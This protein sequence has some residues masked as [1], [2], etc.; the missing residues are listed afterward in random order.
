MPK[1]KYETIYQQIRKDITD[2]T[3]AFG[4]YLPSENEYAERFSCTRNTVRRAL[5]MLTGEGFLQPRHGRGVQVIYRQEQDRNLFTVGGIES[6]VEAVR[7]NHRKASTKILA[8]QEIVADDAI[9]RVTGFEPGARLYYIERLRLMDDIAVIRDINMYLMSETPGLTPEIAASSIYR[10]LEDELHMTITT[11]RRRVTAEKPEPADLAC[12]DLSEYP[13]LLVV[14]GQVF[15][16]N[17]V[18]FEYTQSRHRPDLVCLAETA[19][20][21]KF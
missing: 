9:S 20:R 2:G 1:A 6:F 4:D 12:L 16:S 21:Q 13:F 3:Y 14:S 5:S 7:R 18:L 17:G 10:Y 15:N 8:F 19:V 11:S